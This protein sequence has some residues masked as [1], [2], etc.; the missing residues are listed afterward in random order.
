MSGNNGLGCLW[1]GVLVVAA[2]LFAALAFGAP[3]V[4][5]F[6]LS[7]DNSAALARE[8]QRTERTRIE[9]ARDIRLE[10]ERGETARQVVGVL[11]I[12]GGI[13]V[14]GWTVQRSVT[15]WA[16]RPHRPVAPPPVVVMLAAPTLAAEPQARLEWSEDDSAWVIVNERTETVKLLEDRTQRRA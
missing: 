15:A 4:G 12:V 14:A 2:I 3:N 5:E 10:E 7:W 8:A 13:A 16:A 9:A 6:G 11:A 1:A